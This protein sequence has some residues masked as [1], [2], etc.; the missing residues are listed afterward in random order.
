METWLAQHFI[1]PALA[2]GG[3]LLL[4]A[5]IIIHLINRLRF[6]R[7]RFAAM[8]FLLQ[9]EQRN[10]RRILLEQLLLLLMRLLIVA[11]IIAL[12]ARLILNPDQL[13]IFQGAK[14]H[15][16]VLLD[17]SGSMRDRWGETTAFDQAKKMIQRLIA[18]GA[19]RPET[20]QF[21]LILLSAPDAPIFVQKDLDSAFQQE[22][23]SRLENLTS[24]H[25][26][27]DLSTGIKA[28]QQLLAE[29]KGLSKNVHIL[30]D[31][32]RRDWLDQKATASLLQELTDADV[33]VNLIKIVPER[34]AN[35]S[36][37]RLSGAVQVAAVG[38]PLRLTV[39]VKNHGDKTVQ[40]VGVS[41]M[42]DG[43]K[44]PLSTVFEKIEPG[45]EVF[46]EFDVVFPTAGAHKL[47]VFLD[48]DSLEEDNTRFLAID[49]HQTNPILIVDGNA[50]DEESFH[51][52]TAL[53]PGPQTTGYS[54]T[55]GDA[56]TLRRNP[57]EGYQS[58][59]L[60]NVSELA[61][62]AVALLE[63]YVRNG[64]GLAWFLG[65]TVKATFYNEV[66]YREGNGLFPV[67]INPA[68]RLLSRD[69]LSNAPDLVFGN[70]PI[71]SVF[72]GQNNPLIETVYVHRY[73]ALEEE[74]NKP[75]EATDDESTATGVPTQ[76]VDIIARL[77]N[78][79]PLIFEHKY[80]DGKILTCLT[81]AGPLLGNDGIEWNDW[82]RNPS[83]IV[84]MLEWQKHIAR[85]NRQWGIR[86]V[87]EPIVVSVDPALYSD[88]VEIIGPEATGQRV[89][90][91]QALPKVDTVKTD[92]S[93][94][95][96]PIPPTTVVPSANSKVMLVTPE[97]KETDIPGIYGIRLTM[98]G[99]TPQ[100]E[101]ISY[102]FPLSEGELELATTAEIRKTL[103]DESPIQILE[104]DNYQWMQGEDA[105]QEIRN[106][107]LIL[108]F[109]LLVGEQLLACRLSFH[110]LARKVAA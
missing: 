66:L 99:Q 49:V 33:S 89:T 37:T 15:H 3:A 74:K 95:E 67:R 32:R 79:A 58:I 52:T 12:I 55:V 78:D 59:Y 103:G 18:E 71:F 19:Q 82:G 51:L 76:P 25:Q 84:C 110:P 62:D 31:F 23:E 53:S 6:K 73:F 94:E 7:V 80:G 77:R 5:P 68:P 42:A 63:E 87:G 41:V 102:N 106:T 4:A 45:T 46:R 108:L 34:H 16:V 65:D 93:A 100:D 36:I 14:T 28:S 2:T 50:A 86:D 60:I 98:H 35:L 56:D 39:G 1:N 22:L 109:L 30:S 91:I 96:K 85:S 69:E 70:H 101:L 27:L 11:G 44:L 97:F 10:R 9:S 54:V 8:E 20:Q 105:G 24:S 17:D 21:S 90:P 43:R 13:S 81:S 40:D 29:D 72:T 38:V 104:P 64:G 61:P 75:Q 83:F 107:I 88:T 57:L 92:A 26:A 48:G 47:R